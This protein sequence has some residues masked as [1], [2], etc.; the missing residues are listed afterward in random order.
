MLVASVVSLIAGSV[1]L[2]WDPSPSP[3]VDGYRIYYVRGTNTVFQT[4]NTNAVGF[5]TVTNQLTVT[6][7]NLTS[8]AWSF[9]ATALCSTNGLESDNSNEVWTVVPLRGPSVLRITTV[10][11]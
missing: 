10:V 11:P 9:V 1:S 5:V 7:S 2:A 8:G 4:G 3:E 6:V